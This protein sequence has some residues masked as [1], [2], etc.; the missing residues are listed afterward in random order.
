[1]LRSVGSAFQSLTK[2]DVEDGDTDMLG[3]HQ[4]KAFQDSINDF[5]RT[6]HWV[7]VRMKRQILGLEEA[8]IINQQPKDGGVGGSTGSKSKPKNSL[9]A[10]GFGK[11]AGMDP[12]FLNSRSNK[13]EREM[14]AELWEQM[15]SFLGERLEEDTN[16]SDGKDQP[17]AG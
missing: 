2:Q 9:E 8:G 10:D 16:Q 14:E 17:M 6:L 1:M 13:V 12:G 15:K 4:N 11:I 3:G 7:D 5:L